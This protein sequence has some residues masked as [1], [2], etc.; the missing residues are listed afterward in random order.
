M[1]DQVHCMAARYTSSLLA[2]SQNPKDPKSE[3]NTPSLDS[4]GE[5]L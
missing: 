1:Q 5:V 4:L 2:V 3:V